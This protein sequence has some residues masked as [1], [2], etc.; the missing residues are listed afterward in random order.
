MRREGDAENEEM[1]MKKQALLIALAS[2]LALGAVTA[3]F[4]HEA[5]RVTPNRVYN[6]YAPYRHYAPYGSGT[7]Y[8]P[9]FGNIGAGAGP[10]ED[11]K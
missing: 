7:V 9:G 10:G 5:P 2:A 11:W 4:A 6:H 3:A 1:K 8:V